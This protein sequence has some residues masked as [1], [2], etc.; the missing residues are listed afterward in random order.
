MN[1]LCL[2]MAICISS[3]VY[4]ESRKLPPIINNSTYANG[5]AY[6]GQASSNQPMLE[7]LVRVEALQVE[8]QQLRGTIEQQNHEINNL[9][10]R[11]QNIYTDMNMRLQQLETGAGISIDSSKSAVLYTPVKR[12]NTTIPTPVQR[13]KPKPVKKAKPRSKA[14]EKSAF[15]KAFTSVK[16]SHYQQAIKQLEQ[17]LRDYPNGT[18]SDNAYFWLGSVY[19]VVNDIPAAQKNFEAVY[20]QFPK[21]EKA[22][23][24][25]L[26]LADI[27][28]E[29][30]DSAKAVQL[31]TQIT[32]QYAD[33][34][35]VHI[36][37]K[38]LQNIGQ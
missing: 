1:K 35:A 33:S 18:Y 13:A 34:T 8:V 2:I 3:T 23:M 26:K 31:Y 17:F 6:S 11:Q 36:A 29:E 30:N 32:S 12:Q 4:A 19:K 14:E 10:Q 20:T 28:R 27:Y 15:D 24:A 22:G 25:M 9:K 5:A 37:E 16:D 38:K 7:M 21:S